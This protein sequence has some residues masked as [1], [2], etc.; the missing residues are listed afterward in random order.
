MIKFFISSPLAEFFIPRFSALIGNEKFAQRSSKIQAK[1]SQ[2]FT[3]I[4]ANECIYLFHQRGFNEILCKAKSLEYL[5][6]N[7]WQELK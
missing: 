4:Y 7:V 3:I 5:M 2:F 1:A 6:C